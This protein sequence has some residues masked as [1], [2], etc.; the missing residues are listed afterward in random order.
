MQPR[1]VRHVLIW[2]LGE[3]PTDYQLREPIHVTEKRGLP[4][5]RIALLIGALE[6]NVRV[7]A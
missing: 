6:R 2:H 5:R 3:L 4:P 7:V 1:L